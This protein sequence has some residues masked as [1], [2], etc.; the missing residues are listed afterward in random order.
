[1][2]TSSIVSL[3]KIMKLLPINPNQDDLTNLLIRLEEQGFVVEQTTIDH[4]YGMVNFETME[5]IDQY[6]HVIT[7]EY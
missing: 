1:M 4:V 6:S 3:T 2:S 5:I 7:E